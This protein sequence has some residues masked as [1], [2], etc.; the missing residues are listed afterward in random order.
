MTSGDFLQ[1]ADDWGKSKE[2]DSLP[3]RAM[4]CIVELERDWKDHGGCICR[5]MAIKV[6]ARC[7][8][9]FAKL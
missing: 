8:S 9:P 3:A 5:R 7:A 4:R 2:L 1:S 6:L